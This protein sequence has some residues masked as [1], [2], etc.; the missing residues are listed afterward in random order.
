MKLK[1]ESKTFRSFGNCRDALVH[2]TKQLYEKGC[3]QSTY[4][5][6]LGT[7]DSMCL[8]AADL[9]FYIPGVKDHYSHL[10]LHLFKANVPSR[11]QIQVLNVLYRKSLLN[12][13][14]KST[15]GSPL[16]FFA[17]QL[18]SLETV[19]HIFTKYRPDILDQEGEFLKNENHS[20][21]RPRGLP[22]YCHR[23]AIDKAIAQYIVDKYK[24][25]KIA[26]GV[27]RW[28]SYASCG[29]CRDLV[30]LFIS[31]NP[32][33]LMK[34]ESTQVRTEITY[35]VKSCHTEKTVITRLISDG[36]FLKMETVKQ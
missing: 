28:A 32:D 19:E 22:D 17:V 12:V 18:C 11:V 26:E 10:I 2:I 21:P 20:V 7:L 34:T 14:L 31:K 8:T 33:K 30:D 16:I 27:A 15:N 36:T 3:T 5:T 23:W 13:N 24:N 9:L 29:I 1:I 4:N 6:L 25:Q 35:A